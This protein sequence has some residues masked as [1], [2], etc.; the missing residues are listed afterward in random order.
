MVYGYTWYIVKA[1]KNCHHSSNVESTFTG[2]LTNAE[3]EVFN[4]GTF[5]LWNF[6]H[7]CAHNLCGHVVW[8]KVDE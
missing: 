8:T 2:W 7:E 4:V 6:G 3:H 5:H 1:S